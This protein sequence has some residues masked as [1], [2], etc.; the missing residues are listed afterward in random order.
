MALCLGPGLEAYLFFYC[1]FLRVRVRGIPIA[2]TARFFGSGL[3]AYLVRTANFLGP[4][5][6]A[7]L[8]LAA[9]FFP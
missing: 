4:G 9:L 3:E 5:L 2:F 6:E 1:P 7:Y 8:L